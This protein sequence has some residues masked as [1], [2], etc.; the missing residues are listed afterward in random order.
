MRKEEAR[1]IVELIAHVVRDKWRILDRSESESAGVERY[2]SARYSDICI[3]MNKRIALSDLEI[4]LDDAEIPYRLEGGSLVFSTQEV[5]DSMNCLR[6]IDDPSDSVAVVAALRSPAFACSDAALLD[7]YE[8]GGRFDYL[9]KSNLTDGA[10]GKGLSTLREYHEKR[11]WT[12][13]AYLIDG[14]IRSRPFMQV[15]LDDPRMRQ[16]W[17]RYRFVVDQ[18]RA[19]ANSGGNSLRAFL[20]WMERQADE[21]ARL[22]ETPVPESDE[23]AVRIMTVHGAKGLEFPIVVLT[24]IVSD[25]TAGSGVAVLFDREYGA[26]EARVSAGR[27]G[28]PFETAGYERLNELEKKLEKDE[29]ARLMYVAATRARDHLVVS[30]YRAGEDKGISGYIVGILADTDDAGDAD[31]AIWKPV[32]FP[33]AGL[34]SKPESSLDDDEVFRLEDHT[35][36]ARGTLDGGARGPYPASGAARV[37]IGYC[38]CANRKAGTGAR[39]GSQGAVEA[40][41]GRHFDRTRRARRFADSRSRYRRG[42]RRDCPRAGQRRERA[43][44]GGRDSSSCPL[45]CR[46]RHRAQSSSIRPVLA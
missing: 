29:L 16:K 21:R 27:G 23:D 34:L 33:S 11:M 39:A 17:R 2:K 3:L 46:K 25:H 37:H 10:V 41:Q 32:L 44:T 31:D 42:H 4:E 30:V 26:A 22:N 36:E 7:F 15:A 28:E 18:A 13:L 43:R 35:L 20:S 40:R 1:G 5:R 45:C 6:A 19:F 14:F 8:S 12:P 9:R 24:G 38:A